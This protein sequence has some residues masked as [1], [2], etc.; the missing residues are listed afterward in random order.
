MAQF[1]DLSNEVILCIWDQLSSADVI[2]SFSGLNNRI[3]SLLSEFYGLYKEL[4]IGYCS[5]S[6]CRF[7]CRQVASMIE[8]RLGLTTLKIGNVYRCCQMDMFA[9]EVRK[10]LIRSHFSRQGKSFDNIS[11]DAFRLIMAYSKNIQPMF[12]QLV[13]FSVFQS[14]LINEDNRDILLFGVA[15]GSSMRNF[16]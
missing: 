6:A 1:E 12:P 7:L 8:W 3:N 2:Y 13:S 14:I 16:N 11:K 15:G 5:L 4:N 9:S 10:F